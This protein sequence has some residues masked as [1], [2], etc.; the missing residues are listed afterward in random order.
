M[1]E[2]LRSEFE[3]LFVYTLRIEM[4]NGNVLFY[5]ID[6]ENK[7]YLLNKLE[8][9]SFGGVDSNIP[10]IW[11]ETSANRTAIINVDFIVRIIFCV[12]Y[13][14]YSEGFNGYFDNFNQ[15]DRETSIQEQK[16]REGVQLHV[17]EQHF[18][19]KAIIFHKGKSASEESENNL[20]TYWELDDGCLAS[21][22]S[23]LEGDVPFRQFINLTDD[24][25]EESFIPIKQII[26][27]EVDKNLVSSEIEEEDEHIGFDDDQ[28]LPF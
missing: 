10:F 7:N 25:G 8:R 24:D 16:T 11:F 14:D 26:A 4:N 28:D 5:Q 17:V 9:N 19:P 18:L 3:K 23:E 21:F 6:R 2:N 15:L 22:L 1:K 20:F 12:D 27:M 13:G